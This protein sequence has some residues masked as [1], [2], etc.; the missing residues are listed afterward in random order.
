ML[1]LWTLYLGSRVRGA[2]LSPRAWPMVYQMMLWSK[3]LS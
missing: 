2:E 1:C 3:Q